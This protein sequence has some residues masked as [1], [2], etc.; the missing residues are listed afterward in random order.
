VIEVYREFV[1]KGIIPLKTD[2]GNMEILIIGSGDVA[3]ERSLDRGKNFYPMTDE[4]G[5]P[6][7]FSSMEDEGVILNSQIQTDSQLVRYRLVTENEVKV[8]LAK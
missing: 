7:V 5:D 8:V 4:T 6:V 1:G 2:G 3:I